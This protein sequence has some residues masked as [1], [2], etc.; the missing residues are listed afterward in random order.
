MDWNVLIKSGK[1]LDLDDKNISGY[2]L[3]ICSF[4]ALPKHKQN[5]DATTIERGIESI[6]YAG[7]NFLYPYV[8][9]SDL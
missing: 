8:N 9:Y 7:V 3:D 6:L 1:C 2:C 4:F 5:P